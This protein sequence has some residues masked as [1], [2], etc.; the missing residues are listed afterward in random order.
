MGISVK[1]KL[2]ERYVHYSYVQ[3][4]KNI[5]NQSPMTS[6]NWDNL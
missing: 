6:S 5:I 3:D 4:S 2:G 1:V